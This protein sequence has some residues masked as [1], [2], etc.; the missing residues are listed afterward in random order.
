MAA[1]TDGD[2]AGGSRYD[3]GVQ[4]SLGVQVGDGNI[5]YINGRPAVVWPA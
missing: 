1:A 2:R 3:V 5:M 4:D